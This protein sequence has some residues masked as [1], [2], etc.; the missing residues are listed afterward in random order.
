MAI[1][2][3]L[4]FIGG[5][6][7]PG[8]VLAQLPDNPY[9]IV[10]DSGWEHAVALGFIPDVLVGD[11]DSI[12]P[13]HLEDARRGGVEII[14]YPSDKDFTDTELALSTGHDRG[15]IDITVISGGGDRF[16]H[17]LAM[18]HSLLPY[19]RP[20]TEIVCHLAHARID[21]VAGGYSIGLA[22][23]IGETISLIPLGGDATGVTTTG[24]TWNLS[25][26]TL[27]ATSSRGVSNITKSTVVEISVTTGLLAIIQPFIHNKEQQ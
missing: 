18:M 1:Q 5:D 17:L 9:V 12:R 16:D 6:P 20:P 19:A 14:E 27:S 3:L 13:Q 22:V 24:L 10:A 11:M 2:P 8:S 25:A 7:P 23:D 26:N 4:I 21:F 15:F